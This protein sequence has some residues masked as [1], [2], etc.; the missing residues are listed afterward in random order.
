VTFSAE[1][2]AR[3]GEISSRYAARWW[4]LFALVLGVLAV[5][6]DST[7]LS[8]AIPTLAKDL[9]ATQTQVQWFS[10]SF[11]LALAAAMLPMGLLGDRY[12]RRLVMILS[13]IIFG[14]GS[15]ACAYATGPAFFIAARAVMGIA[16]AGVTV[17]AMSSLVVL[18]PSAERPKAVSAWAGA[19]FLALPI[20]PILGGWMLTSYWWGWVF[21]INIPICLLGVVALVALVPESSS[22]EH[23]RLDALGI[24]GSVAGLVALT[25]GITEAG[26]NGWAS[27]SAWAWM[28]GGLT[29]LGLLAAWEVALAGRGGHPL[30]DPTLFRSRAFTSGVILAG[31]TMMAA[32]GIL[33]VLPQFSQGVAGLDAMGSGVRLLPLIGGMV[34]G[35]LPS[36]RI[37]GALGPKATVTI[38]FLLLGV[39][40]ALGAQTTADS[41]DGFVSLWLAISGCGTGLALSAAAST[42]LSELDAEGSGVGSAVMQAVQKLGGPLGIAILYSALSSAYRGHLTLPGNLPNAAVEAIKDSFF[43]GL[44][45]AAKLGSP[46]L[47]D[48]VQ[49][50]FMKGMTTSLWVS[51]ALAALGALV[52][53]VFLPQ[54]RSARAVGAVRA[55]AARPTASPSMTARQG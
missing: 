39:G 12:G 55:E 28:L 8:V 6:L 36:A 4:A 24:V 22:S 50:A 43:A 52:A 47:A 42:A 13:L 30:I 9:G 5:G 23:G 17:L 3:A 7:V 2:A 33:F 38:G 15:A 37:T 18:F 29:L 54:R 44:G 45:V 34:V 10:N 31:M 46:Q 25:Y 11:M 14:A 19:S 49:A 21:L 53:L 48:A 32:I 26:E 1:T 51:V 20:G 41:S 35:L 27:I 16:G 40:A